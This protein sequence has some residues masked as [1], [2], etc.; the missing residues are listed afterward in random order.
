MTEGTTSFGLPLRRMTDV[1]PFQKVNVPREHVRL[2]AGSHYDTT[3]D[4]AERV[5]KARSYRINSCAADPEAQA[6][7]NPD[8]GRQ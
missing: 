3:R 1:A 8:S 4:W 6:M 2:G 7:K 5:S